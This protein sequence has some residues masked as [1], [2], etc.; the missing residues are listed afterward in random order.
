MRDLAITHF[1]PWDLALPEI[2]H[3]LL[4]GI[5]SLGSRP[6]DFELTNAKILGGWG[7]Q[8]AD[9]ATFDVKNNLQYMGAHRHHQKKTLKAV[10]IHEQ[11]YMHSIHATKATSIPTKSS[12]VVPKQML[13]K[14]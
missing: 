3:I 14:S 8:G 13:D 6:A 7:C 4:W 1:L 10:R 9:L 2:K 5:L 12:K 11:L